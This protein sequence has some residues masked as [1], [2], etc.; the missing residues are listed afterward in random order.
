MTTPPGFAT[1][2][3]YFFVDDAERFVAF[4]IEGLGGE[5]DQTSLRED[6]KIANA[7]V[8]SAMRR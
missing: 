2:T 8:T 5:H 7:Q 3:A 6:G 4:L 1:V